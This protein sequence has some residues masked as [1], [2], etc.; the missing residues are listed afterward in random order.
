MSDCLE[1]SNT[2]HIIRT[3][4]NHRHHQARIQ[5]TKEKPE[6]F[7]DEELKIYQNLEKNL[8]IVRY[9]IENLR[10]ENRE[11]IESLYFKGYSM[12]DYARAKGMSKSG[13][14]NRKRAAVAV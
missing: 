13:I 8:L 1:N 4:N 3:L 9:C 5:L 7:T 11:V 6:L 12:K 10:P 2:E 14:N